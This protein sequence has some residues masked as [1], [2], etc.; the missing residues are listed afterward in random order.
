VA[1]GTNPLFN[2]NRMKLGVFALNVSGGCAMT[3]AAGRFEPVWSDVLSIARMAD[4]AGIEAL[5]PIARWK[6]FGGRT[7]FNGASFESYTWAAAVAAATKRVAVF[8]T[9]HVT[10]V[11]PVLAAKQATTIDHVSGGRFVLNVVSGWFAP[12]LE[13]FG[14]PMPGRAE[15]YGYAAEWLR[16]MKLLWT[17]EDEV[18]F[19]G[20]Y[21]TLRKGYHQPKPIQR[22]YPPVMYAGGSPVSRRFA[23]E[24]ADV[25]FTFLPVHDYEGARTQVAALREL[26]RREF[27]REIQVWVMAYVVCRPTEREAREY[28]HHYVEEEGDWEGAESFVR[29]MGLPSTLSREAKFHFVAG[30]GGHPLVGTP[31]LVVDELLMLSQAGIDGC[32]LSWVNYREGLL[33]WVDEVLPLMEQAGLRCPE[34]GPEGR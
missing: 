27:G 31:Q 25:A 34:P 22:P 2:G 33:Q 12:E 21:F 10:T 29:N 19:S 18:D 30:S 5:A 3:S 26:A 24:H 6:G 20:R 8:S 4:D 15:R 32:L 14:I 1:E 23:A 13:M 7:N 28:L 11:H 9:S 16:V 17:A